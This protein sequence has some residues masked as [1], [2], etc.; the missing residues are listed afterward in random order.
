MNQS[1]IGIDL[2]GINSCAAVFLNGKVEIIPSDLGERKT[3]SYVAFTEEGILIGATAKNQLK[4]NQKNV[5]FNVEKLI[6]R[7]Y[8]EKN[9]GDLPFKVIKDSKTDKSQIQFIYK[10]EEK[11]YYPE[12]ILAMIL[13][14]YTKKSI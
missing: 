12:N 3:P 2:G 5:I 8:E 9:I 1:A 6:R 4:K 11:K 14:H 13:Q 7:K 10:N